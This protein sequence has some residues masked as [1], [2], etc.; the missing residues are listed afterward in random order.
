MIPYAPND[1]FGLVKDVRAYPDFIKWIDRLTV[2]NESTVASVERCLAD[3]TVRF[4]GFE[5]QFSTFVDAD[6]DR[7]RIDVRLHRG[8]FRRLL[9]RWQFVGREDGH[10]RVHFYL[11]YAFENPALR[12]LAKTSS[13][14]AA[15]KIIEAFQT[16]ADRRFGPAAG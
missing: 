2:G 7:H 12:L 11:D 9:N 5:E 15:Q 8:P 10:T 3:V 4:K 16:E 13:R 6:P 1:L 14:K